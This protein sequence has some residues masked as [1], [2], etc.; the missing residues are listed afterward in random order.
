[1]TPQAPILERPP[2]EQTAPPVSSQSAPQP[3]VYQPPIP[4]AG[5]YVPQ[6][7]PAQQHY[8]I[9]SAGQRLGLAIA[10]IAMLIP[11]SAIALGTIA[12]LLPNVA[13]GVSVAT[14]LIALALV[15]FAVVAVN[16]AFNFD[17]IRPKR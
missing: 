10:S 17:L 4:P 1:M 14:G 3:P 9:P 5:W 7:V 8:L 12:T 6:V 13:A 2:V 16:I 11:L 15:C